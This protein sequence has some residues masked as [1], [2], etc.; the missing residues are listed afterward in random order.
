VDRGPMPAGG[1]QLRAV[2]RTPVE[3]LE[4]VIDLSAGLGILLLPLFITAVPGVILMLVLP[5]VLLIAAAA[6]PV[7]IAGAILAPPYLLVRSVRRRRRRA[8]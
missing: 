6:V 1:E 5:A 7:A 4:D 8:A 2:D 3:M